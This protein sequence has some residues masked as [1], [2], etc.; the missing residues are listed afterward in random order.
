MYSIARIRFQ[1]WP[2]IIGN[3]YYQVP[4]KTHLNRHFTGNWIR[5]EDELI[6]KVLVDGKNMFLLFTNAYNLSHCL[7]MSIN[8]HRID[9]KNS[10]KLW[11]HHLVQF[12]FGLSFEQHECFDRVYKKN[13]FQ[14]SIPFRF[15]NLSCPWLG[16]IRIPFSID[17]N[18]I[19]LFSVK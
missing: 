19:A 10:S 15:H 9:A 7:S 1:S 3:D 16:A 4:R 14:K 18:N 13:V 11:V 17:S 6:P 2:I 12:S 8:Q 5:F